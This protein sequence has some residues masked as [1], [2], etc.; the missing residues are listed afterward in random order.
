MDKQKRSKFLAIRLTPDEHEALARI[1]A[2]HT[3]SLASVLRWGVR[4]AMA[5]DADQAPSAH[6]L[7]ETTCTPAGQA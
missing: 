7:T 4:R 1:A 6:L 3:A 2:E 5:E